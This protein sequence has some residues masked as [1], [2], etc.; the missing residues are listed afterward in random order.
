MK[1]SCMRSEWTLINSLKKFHPPTINSHFYLNF[2]LTISVHTLINN[3][4]CFIQERYSCTRLKLHPTSGHFL[5]QSH[6]NY[7]A[8]FSV[9]KPF[10][11][12]K[13]KRFE[14]HKV[15]SLF[16]MNFLLRPCWIILRR[17]KPVFLQP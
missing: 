14:G 16:H 17:L 7:I 10:K 1:T 15:R 13:A 11:M 4:C 3:F 5:A 12:N 8:L 9:N 2:L 6:G